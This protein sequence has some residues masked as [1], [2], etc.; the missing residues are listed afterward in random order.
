M[1]P[2]EKEEGDR[3]DVMGA[4]VPTESREKTGSQGSSTSHILQIL[5]TRIP[6]SVGE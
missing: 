2:R 6:G 1:T 3:K 5:F 4:M